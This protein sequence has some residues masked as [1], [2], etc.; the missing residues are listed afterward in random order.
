MYYMH[1]NVS[2][3][4]FW[5]C[6]CLFVKSNEVAQL[7]AKFQLTLNWILLRLFNFMIIAQIIVRF[8]M[9]LTNMRAVNMLVIKNMP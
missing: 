4:S 5:P 8:M 2:F 3:E 7:Y 9:D 6:A 1:F